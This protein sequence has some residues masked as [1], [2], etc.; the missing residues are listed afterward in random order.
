MKPINYA[1]LVV[2]VVMLALGLAANKAHAKDQKFGV[3]VTL[4]LN[5]KNIGERGTIT[6]YGESYSSTSYY[7]YQSIDESVT[8]N[9]TN[10]DNRIDNR[11]SN[12]DRSIHTTTN[13]STINNTSN[14]PTTVQVSGSENHVQV[15]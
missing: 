9:T 10:N 8:T 5:M 14:T 7:S 13:N 11:V 4:P 6:I 3:S 1:I 15:H 2:I 12:T